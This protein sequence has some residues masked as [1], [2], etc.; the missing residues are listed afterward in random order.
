[1]A[2]KFQKKVQQEQVIDP[3]A[4]MEV[5]SNVEIVG[6]KKEKSP[7][8]DSKDDMLTINC[9][10]PIKINGQRYEGIV[11]VRRGIA[12]LLIEMLSKK[13]R[14]DMEI[15]VGRSHL[16]ERIAGSNELVITDEQT[17]K[18]VL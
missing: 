9:A 12:N 17:K 1:M 7:V 18:R 13:R 8:L 3:L 10:Y 6:D 16:V 15:F 5:Q 4:G 11:T 14:A 2:K